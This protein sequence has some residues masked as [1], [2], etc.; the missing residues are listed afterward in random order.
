MKKRKA[1]MLSVLKELQ[2]GQYS[3]STNYN[4]KPEEFISIAS[5]MVHNDYLSDFTVMDMSKGDN[6]MLL[7]RAKVTTKGEEFLADNSKSMRLYQEVKDWLSI[8]T[9]LV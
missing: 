4:I 3:C 9:S 6:P 7:R 2:K 8:V 5:E 1:I